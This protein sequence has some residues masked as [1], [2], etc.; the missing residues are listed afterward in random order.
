MNKTVKNS[1]LKNNLCINCG[2]CKSVC[3]KSAVILKPDKYGEYKPLINQKDCINCGICTEYCPNTKEKMQ[4]EALKITSI[5]E[6]HTFGLQNGSYYLAYGKDSSLRQKCCSGGVVTEFA[7]YLLKTGRIQAMVHVERLWANKGS[8]HYGARISN[9]I[10]DIEN[11]VSSAYQP[12]D[13]S[14]VLKELKSGET[15]FI[16]GTPCIIRGMRKLFSENEKFKNIKVILCALICSHNTNSQIADYLFDSHNLDDSECW[17]IN[18]RNKDNIPDANNYN[19]HFYT[20]KIDLLKMNR[21]KSGWTQIWRSHYFAMNACLYCSDFWGYEA[22]ISVKD[23]WG[24]WSVDPLGKS[25]VILRNKELEQV[26]LNSNIEV[27]KLNYEVIKEHQ[28]PTPVFKQTNAKNKNFK[29]FFSKSNRKN[30]LFR[31]KVISNCSKFF[32]NYLGLKLTQKIIRQ[33]EK[34]IDIGEKL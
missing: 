27:E 18:T 16:T 9:T 32:Y 30:G 5:E 31:Y 10:E 34:L 11:N 21:N 14:G 2:I 23:A 12:I 25:I 20:K 17:Q 1:T 24:Q 28:K 26:F 15:Y 7:K 13:F 33:V 29:T 22:D 4:K 3:P 6:P 8:L 19:N